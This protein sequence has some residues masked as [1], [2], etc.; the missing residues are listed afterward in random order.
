M[1]DYEREKLIMTNQR[2]FFCVKWILKN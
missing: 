2:Q 1:N